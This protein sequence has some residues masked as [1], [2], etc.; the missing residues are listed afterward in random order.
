MK[1]RAGIRAAMLDWAGTTVDHGSIA[2]VV[3]LQELFARHGIVLSAEDARGDMGLLKRDHIAAILSLPH[4]GDAW[5]ALTGRR[6]EAGD[7]ALLFDEFRPLQASIIAEHSNVIDGVAETVLEWQVRGLRIGSTTGYTREMLAPVLM[8]AAEE[9]YRP[10]SSVCPDEVGSGRP[11]PWM[12][13]RNA[14]ILDVYP[15]SA[16]VKIGD[17]VSDI[18]EGLNAGM[19]TIGI[20]RTGNLVGLDAESWK[21]LSPSEKQRRLKSAEDALR[22]AGAHFVAEDLPGCDS[23]LIE[24]D[25][26]LRKG[27]AAPAWASTETPRSSS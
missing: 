10:D 1:Q 25:Q 27:L 2:P 21:I 20:T 6:P 5:L 3:A 19:W 18:E 11:A 8:R 17:T 9:G 13:A 23:I 26:R 16:C 24:I 7:V 22:G 15:P 12:L 14:Q 4:I